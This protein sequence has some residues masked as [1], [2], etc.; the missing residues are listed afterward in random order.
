MGSKPPSLPSNHSAGTVTPLNLGLI[1]RGIGRIRE[2]MATAFSV[3]RSVPQN[4]NP[5]AFNL[6]S[7]GR[8]QDTGD[9]GRGGRMESLSHHLVPRGREG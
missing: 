4:D 9:R 3:D 1:C 6:T 7:M 5:R 2:A 8:E